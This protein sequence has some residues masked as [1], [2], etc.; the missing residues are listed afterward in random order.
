MLNDFKYLKFVCKIY[1]YLNFNSKLTDKMLIFNFSYFSVL[2]EIGQ[3]RRNGEL[4]L[5]RFGAGARAPREGAR[6]INSTL[7]VG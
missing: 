3:W 2:H 1:V 7:F 4:P 5:Q 6:G